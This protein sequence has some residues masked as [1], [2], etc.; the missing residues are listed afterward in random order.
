MRHIHPYQTR[1]RTSTSNDQS[2]R[3]DLPHRA[4]L[5]RQGVGEGEVARNPILHPELHRRDRVEEHGEV[6]H[7]RDDVGEGD[8]EDP[9]VG[10]GLDSV[11]EQ[12]EGTDHRRESR[13]GLGEV[14]LELQERLGIGGV[15]KEAEN[16]QKGDEE[17]QGFIPG[18]AEDDRQ[19][20]QKLEPHLGVHLR[21]VFGEDGTSA[22]HSLVQNTDYPSSRAGAPIRLVVS[23]PS[24][25]VPHELSLH[26]PDIS[27]VQCTAC[28]FSCTSL[29]GGS[30]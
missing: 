24:L 11:H 28:L 5:Q 22:C 4:L 30:H 20:E 29:G 16:E 17:T 18:A 3:D 12:A 21:V 27:N 8:Q 15:G 13:D 2:I 9:Y 6:A 23:Y 1:A 19:D 7:R 14:Q 26:A 10:M 25:V